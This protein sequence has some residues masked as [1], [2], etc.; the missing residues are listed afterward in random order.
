MVRFESS[1]SAV[2][3]A[4]IQTKPACAGFKILV[5]LLVREGGLRL[6]SRDFQS[7]GA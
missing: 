2:E 1:L 4:A 7:P 5:L 6:Y 3:T